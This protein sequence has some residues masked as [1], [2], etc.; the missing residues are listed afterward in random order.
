MERKQIGEGSQNSQGQSWSG[1]G[2]E[3]TPREGFLDLSFRAMV[4]AFSH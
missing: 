3:T 4:S 2:A 1:M